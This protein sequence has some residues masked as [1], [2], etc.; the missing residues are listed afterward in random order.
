MAAI[1]AMRQRTEEQMRLRDEMLRKNQEQTQS[2]QQKMDTASQ[3]P[4]YAQ[5]EPQVQKPVT[6]KEIKFLKMKES[7]WQ[8]D[9]PYLKI[10]F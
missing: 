2:Y 7:K 10:N 1:E 3:R 5:P 4:V 6:N 9:V 8:I